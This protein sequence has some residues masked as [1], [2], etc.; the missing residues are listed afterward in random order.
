M[1]RIKQAGDHPLARDKA[2]AEAL[3]QCLGEEALDLQALA[4]RKAQ[5]LGG[6]TLPMGFGDFFFDP[7]DPLHPDMDM[8]NDNDNDDEGEPF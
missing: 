1:K 4:Q 2:W 6:Q 8:D 5:T 3:Q 7:N